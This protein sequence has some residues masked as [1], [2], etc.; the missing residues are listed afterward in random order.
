MHPFQF[1][2]QFNRPCIYYSAFPTAAWPMF[3]VQFTDWYVI[4]IRTLFQ[5]TRCVYQYIAERDPSYNM[6]NITSTL[7]CTVSSRPVTT[8]CKAWVCGR[9]FWNLRVRVPSGTWMSVSCECC[10]FSDRGLCYG[11]PTE[12]LCLIDSNLETSTVRRSRLISAVDL[13]EKIHD[14]FHHAFIG[15]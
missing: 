13:W 7:Q 10:V 11:S 12:C 2:S 1:R 14:A 9:S 15:L 8:R 4:G 6:L 5:S 3:E